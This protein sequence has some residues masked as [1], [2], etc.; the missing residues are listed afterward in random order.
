MAL[1]P[2]LVG[3]FFGLLLLAVA[4]LRGRSLPRVPLLL[5]IAFLVWDFL[6]PT[7][8]PLEP[9]LLLAVSLGW[10]GVHVVR[11]PQERWLNPGREAATR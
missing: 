2:H 11:M 10:L 4:G 3:S 8:G 7:V 5:L 1:V 6:L 9:H